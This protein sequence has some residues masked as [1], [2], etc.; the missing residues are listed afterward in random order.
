VPGVHEALGYALVGLFTAVALLGGWLWWRSRTSR[1]F[2]AALRVGQALLIVQAGAGGVL[3]LTGRNVGSLHLLYGLLPL[4]ISFVA[5]GMRV[6]AAATVLDAR[7]H[8]SAQAVGELPEA[9]Q[10]AVVTAI[11]RREL[12]VMTVAAA[13]IAALAVRAAYAL[14]SF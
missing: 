3:L 11:L 7:G 1:T 8:E 5:E 14:G 6:A 4:G 9:D 13:V 2:W 12:G 10:L